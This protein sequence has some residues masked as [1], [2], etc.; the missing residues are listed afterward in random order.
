MVMQRPSALFDIGGASLEREDLLLY[1][2]FL[3]NSLAAFFSFKSHSLYF[4]QSISEGMLASFGPDLDQV[5]YLSPER[6]LLLPLAANGALLGVFVA[7]EVRP[8]PAKS[9]LALLPKAAAQCLEIIRLRKANVT[10]P[11]TG[12][13]NQPHLTGAL[14]RE[15]DLAHELIMPGSAGYLDPSLTGS[16]GCFGLAVA[17]IDGFSRVGEDYGLVFAESILKRLGAV[18][19]AAC[20]EDALAARMNGATF[21]VFLPG[22]S[23]SKTRETAR[24]IREEIKRARYDYPVTEQAFSLTVSIGHANYPQDVRGGQFVA[25]AA[26]QARI[27]LSKAA[28]ALAVA[29]ELGRDQTMDYGRILSEGGQVLDALPMG[30]V[31]VSLGK[32]VDAEG[33]QRFLVWSPELEKTAEARRPDERKLLPGGPSMIKGEI[34]LM[35]VREGMAFAEILHLGDPDWPIAPGDRLL[36]AP[37][38]EAAEAAS[39][40]RGEG[41]GKGVRPKR[42]SLSGLYGHKDFL[43]HLAASVE[44]RKR[45]SLA[46]FR[47]P[48]EAPADRSSP[49]GRHVEADIREI[50]SMCRNVFGQ[51]IDGGRFSASKLLFFFPDKIPEDITEGVAEV[52]ELARERLGFEL[53]VGMAG[54]PYLG[55]SKADVVENCRKALEHALLLP[56][57]PKLAVFD[58]ISL[59]VSADRHFTQGDLYAA[60]EE[61]KL[62]LV[63][64]PKNLLARN[65]LGITLARLG[66]YAKARAEFEQ[67]VKMDGKNAMAAYNLGCALSRLN[68]KA[69]ARKA[70]QKCLRLNPSD[71][72][73][74]LR[75]GR[76]SEEDGRYANALQYYKKA[77]AAEGGGI[78]LRHLARLCMLRG[79][80]EEARE[81]LRQALVFDPRDAF[82]LNLMASL[83]LDGGDDPAI[84]EAMARQSAAL[85]PDRKEFWRNLARALEAQGKS[86][87]AREAFAR[88]E[89]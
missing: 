40:A 3:K 7:K 61:Y 37:E 18:I 8:A 13:F 78:A 74:L 55:L 68:E 70:F 58:S 26:E 76:M 46:L 35:E 52:C 2:Q 31:A 22:A 62:A 48:D 50:V 80:A 21:A 84:A 54:H 49:S 5:S 65:S 51:E 1:E 86:D 30:R 19:Q 82:S 33:G 44:K 47:L 24:R 32:S 28:K 56:E 42:D 79:Q 34:I 87:E 85:R 29:R 89:G 23:P 4:P 11:V 15:I 67:A 41:A 59:T 77:E 39:A 20:P 63:A 60:S 71:V 64:D 9:V 6:R 16:R 12:L 36:L 14:E 43:R 45:F 69:L 53:A 73:S 83:Y 72:F 27:M 25:S 38:T 17:E 10:D 88:A 57:G 81:Y 66:Q 75:L